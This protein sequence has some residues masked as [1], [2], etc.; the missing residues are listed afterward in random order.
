VIRSFLTRVKQSTLARNAAWLFAGQGLSFVVQGLYFIVLARLLGT[1][2]YGLLAG[3][4]ALVAV[5]SQYSPLGSGLLFLRHVSPDHSRFRE[6]WGN[7][8]VSVFLLGGLLVVGL[9]ISGRWFVGEASVSLLIPIAISD[10]LFQQLGSCA[11]QVFQTFEKMKFSAMITLLSNVLRLVLAVGML[12]V[13]KRA[14]AWQWAIAS[15]IVSF[16][17][18]SIAFG[19]V[20]R[21]FGLP[22]F[23]MPLFLKR[24]REGLVFAVSGSTTA[25]YN[26]IDKGVVALRHDAGKWDLLH[27]LSRREHRNDAS[28]V[29]CERRVSAFLSGGRQWH[30]RD[31]SDGEVPVEA[32]SHYGRCDLGRPVSRRPSY[33]SS[34]RQL[35]S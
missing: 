34:D 35:L 17:G 13:L 10:C 18:A 20:T 23:S 12:L 24:I 15:L 29:R 21:F 5:V 8:L 11:G 22:S 27:G 30:P 26:D 25:V 3:V 31:G 14:S 28:H 2:Q 32:D 6:Y 16:I 19:I 7:I 4:V 9:R 1:T 33:S